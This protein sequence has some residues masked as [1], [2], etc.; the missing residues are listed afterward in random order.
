ME[1]MMTDF[2]FMRLALVAFMLL[3]MLGSPVLVFLVVRVCPFE[4]ALGYS[5]GALIVSI[6]IVGVISSQWAYAWQIQAF[7]DI[8]TFVIGYF[9]RFTADSA[10]RTKDGSSAS[11]VEIPRRRYPSGFRRGR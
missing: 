9:I 2:S 10:S 3:A 7:L 6:V 5:V 1:A 8:P 11:S 4:K